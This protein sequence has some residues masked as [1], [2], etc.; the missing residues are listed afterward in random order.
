MRVTTLRASEDEEV[1]KGGEA[2]GVGIQLLRK[3]PSAASCA[4]L[5]LAAARWGVLVI[6]T[7][8]DNLGIEQEKVEHNE[9]RHGV[10]RGGEKR[11]T[12]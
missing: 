9:R 5:L 4:R 1:G 8:E 12:K 6:V 7:I 11:T 10:L 2:G 3:R